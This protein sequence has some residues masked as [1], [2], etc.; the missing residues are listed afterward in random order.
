LDL[1][2]Y[3]DAVDASVVAD[4][5]YEDV[6]TNKRKV[7][8]PKMAKNYALIFKFLPGVLQKTLEKQARDF[9]YT[10]EPQEDESEFSYVKCI[11]CGD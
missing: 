5:A 6:P 11:T 2:D 9:E 3:G 8:I 10:K 7:L 4:A 1:K